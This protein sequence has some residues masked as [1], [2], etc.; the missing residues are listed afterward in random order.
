M[1]IPKHPVID[2]QLF[3]AAF[4]LPISG[5]YFTD[6]GA[7]DDTDSGDFNADD[8]FQIDFLGPLWYSNG[9]A[10]VPQERRA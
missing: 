3:V 6:H 9:A 4:S 7:V 8:T 2:P 5:V 1:R 10:A